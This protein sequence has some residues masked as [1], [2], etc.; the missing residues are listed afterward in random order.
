M[1]VEPVNDGRRD[2]MASVFVRLRP[3]SSPPS[4]P[5]F[6]GSEIGLR[7]R[8]YGRIVFDAYLRMINA[9]LVRFLEVASPIAKTT[10]RTSLSSWFS[11]DRRDDG[12]SPTN[13]SNSRSSSRLKCNQYRQEAKTRDGSSEER[14]AQGEPVEPGK[15]D[16]CGSGCRECVWT[17]YWNAKASWDNKMGKQREYSAFELLE[18]R[19]ME[20][21]MSKG[22]SDDR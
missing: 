7:L 11:T 8:A 5:A 10:C 18:K 1:P 12:T 4:F 15:D 14:L 16:C 17:T 3:S 20:E 6:D 21:K 2:S 9:R 22:A 13:P 19:L